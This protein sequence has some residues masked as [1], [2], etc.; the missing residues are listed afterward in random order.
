MKNNI[1]YLFYS[2]LL[3]VI[4]ACSEDEGLEQVNTGAPS[5][6]A[7]DFTIAQDNSGEVTLYPSAEGANSFIIDFGDG[8]ETSEEIATGNNLTHTYEEGTY[9]V[10]VTAMS[11]S[12]ETASATQTLE[13]SFRAPENLVVNITNNPS[14]PYAIN[15]SAE[16]DYA[17][18]FEV[19]FGDESNEAPTPMM[20]GETIT[21]EYATIGTYIVT[22][23]AL[24]GGTETTT[25]TEEIEIVNP[26]SF[27]ITFDNA[28]INYEFV[29]FNGTSYAVVQNPD[30]SGSN[31]DQNLVGEITNA[32][33]NWEGGS[34]N[35]GIPIDFSGEDKTIQLD[36]WSNTPVSVLL[37]FEGGI[38]G[39]RENEITVNHTGTGWEELSFNFATD[40]ITSYIEGAGDNGQDF[41]P[42]GQYSVMTMFVDGPGTTSGAFYIDNIEQTTSASNMPLTGAPVPQVPEANVISLFSDTYTDVPVSTWMTSWSNASYDEVTVDGNPT[43]KYSALDF[44]GIETPAPYLDASSMTHFHSDIW[45]ANSTQIRIKLVDFGADGVYGGGDDV[46][47]EIAIDNFNQGEWLQLDIALSDFANL[48]TT[49]HIGQ[50]IYSGNPTGAHTIYVDNIYFHN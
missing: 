16:A 19:Y 33:N 8:S 24:S 2:V 50:L 25:Y 26:L 9:E 4:T 37:K 31:P 47:H 40:A 11:I 39:E 13:V 5:N 45:T 42:T 21:H 30:A 12:G 17:A 36:F 20:L 14:N 46:E 23:V 15:I 6:I 38:N 7:V 10:T 22:V 29:T 18:S 48:T 34:F 3:I 27:P 43:K 1:K 41:V 49:G 28:D 44:V 32:G 35:L